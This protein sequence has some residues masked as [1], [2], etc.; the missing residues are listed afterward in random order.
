MTQTY[1]ISLTQRGL[2]F[3]ESIQIFG[4]DLTG[5]AEVSVQCWVCIISADMQGVYHTPVVQHSHKN[6]HKVGDL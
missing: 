1:Q 5:L 3:A 6:L 4:L 2:M